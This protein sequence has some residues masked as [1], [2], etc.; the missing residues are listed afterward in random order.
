MRNSMLQ[1]LTHKT[2]NG[3]SNYVISPYIIYIISNTQECARKPHTGLAQTLTSTTPFT[4][5]ISNNGCLLPVRRPFGRKV[6]YPGNGRRPSLLLPNPS[7]WD[8]GIFLAEEKKNGCGWTVAGRLP[9]GLRL[10]TEGKDMM[11]CRKVSFCHL[12]L[13]QMIYIQGAFEVK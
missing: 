12:D 4:I 1:Y 10:L 2:R 9:Q 13:H 5:T 6:W 7:P 11:I 3:R 8:F